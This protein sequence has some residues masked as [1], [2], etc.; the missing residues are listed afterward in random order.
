MNALS[1]PLAEGPGLRART[2]GRGEVTTDE[3]W[4]RSATLVGQVACVQRSGSP[5]NQSGPGRK[6]LGTVGSGVHRSSGRRG[7]LGPS[8][9]H[10]VGAGTLAAGLQNL[11]LDTLGHS[12][13][14]LVLL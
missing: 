6:L 5:F 2:P 8:R 12:K 10:T 1:E 3:T 11:S 13:V 4:P 9:P 14:F 7:S